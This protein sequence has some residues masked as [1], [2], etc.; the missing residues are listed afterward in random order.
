MN[1][2]KSKAPERDITGERFVRLVAVRKQRDGYWKFRCDC[3]NVVSISKSNVLDGRT[4]SCGCLRREF[5]K[6][7]AIKMAKTM[8]KDITGKRFGMLSV[9]RLTIPEEHPPS[10]T[11]GAY[12]VVRCDCGNLAVKRSRL[13]RSGQTTSCGCRRHRNRPKKKPTQAGDVFGK[14]TALRPVRAKVGVQG[15]RWKCQC[16]CGKLTIARLKDLRFGTTT[17]CGC[18]KA[19]SVRRNGKRFKAA[20]QN[21]LAITKRLTTGTR[22]GV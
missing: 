10:A 15:V 5:V 12:W 1:A 7:R 21:G 3:G 13:I 17:S 9:L 8:S 18:A 14:L 11:R 16:A 4:R 2:K 19:A 22:Q 6:E 20:L